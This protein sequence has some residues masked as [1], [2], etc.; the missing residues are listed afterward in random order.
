MTD[1][2]LYDISIVTATQSFM[3]M[4]TEST[5]HSIMIDNDVHPSDMIYIRYEITPPMHSEMAQRNDYTDG[6]YAPTDLKRPPDV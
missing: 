6:E 5:F 4:P 2:T 1:M 3:S